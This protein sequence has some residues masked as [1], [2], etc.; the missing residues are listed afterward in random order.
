LR[1]AAAATAAATAASV[2]TPRNALRSAATA[3]DSAA[4]SLTAAGNTTA[5]A[6]ATAAATAARDFAN[7]TT[8]QSAADF[9]NFLETARGALETARNAFHARFQIRAEVNPGDEEYVLVIATDNNPTWALQFHGALAAATVPRQRTLNAA[10]QHTYPITVTTPGLLTVETTGS[11]DTAGMLSGQ[12]TADDDS[13]G[14]GNNFKIVAPVTEAADGSVAYT[15]TVDGQT[16][17]TTGAYTLDMDFKVAMQTGVTAPAGVIVPNEEDWGTD[18]ALAIAVDDDEPLQI[19]GR[20]DEDYFLFTIDHESS[21]FL[22]IEA[23]DDTTSAPDAATTGTFYGPTGE[24]AR[25]TN[26]GADS[27]HFRIRAPVEEERAY[28][29]KVTGTT[30]V[31][32]LRVTLDKAEG[33]TLLTVPGAHNGPS[34]VDCSSNEAGEICSPDSGNPVERERYVLNIAESGALDVRTTGSIDTFGTLYGPNGNQIATDDNSGT[35]NNF[36]I[37]V[38]V[39]AGLHLLEVRGKK[40][41]TQGV[42]NLIVNFVPGAEPVDPTEPTPPTTPTSSDADPTGSLEEPPPGG[43]RSGIGIVRGWVCQDAGSGVE[44]RIFDPAGNRVARFTAPYGSARGDVDESVHCGRRSRPNAP[45]GFA[46]QFNYNLLAAGTYTIQAWVGRE[47][48]GLEDPQTNSFKV[49]RI[50]NSEYL[51]RVQSGRVPVADFPR[52]GTTTIL[53]WDQESQNFQIVDFE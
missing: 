23:R 28:L 43:V 46:A 3:L 44:I 24:L 11:T 40:R 2:S 31:Y 29:V 1:A 21:G 10:D 32:E 53:E 8:N 38:S 52:R 20:A 47:Q 26:S 39:G 13:S 4:R 6:A 51:T 12:V 27:S 49:V 35:D 45:I 36:R 42:Y 14:S 30:G 34:S 7:D 37:A 16:A 48:V 25:D 18:D 19:Q 5:A 50:S 17:T 33:G 41:T 22:T 15:V 9:V